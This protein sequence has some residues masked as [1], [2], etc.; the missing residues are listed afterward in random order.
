MRLLHTGCISDRGGKGLIYDSDDGRLMLGEG[1]MHEGN[2]LGE[3]LMRHRTEQ[4][5]I[6]MMGCRAFDRGL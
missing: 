6:G 5:H 3:T 4:V 1:R 2:C